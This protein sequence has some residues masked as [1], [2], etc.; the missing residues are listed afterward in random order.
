MPSLGRKLLMAGLSGLNLTHAEPYERLVAR[1]GDAAP[2]LRAALDAFPPEALRG[3]AEGLGQATFV[4]SSGRVFPR[5]WKASPLLRAWLARLDGLGVQVRLRHRWVGIEPD[6]AL[7]F[8][9]PRGARDV[10]RGRD[11][12]GAGRGEL[13]A[14]RLGRRVAGGGG[15]ARY[16]FRAVPPRELRSARRLVG[17]HGALRRRAA[18]AHCALVRGTQPTRR[19]GDDRRRS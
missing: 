6:G 19:D 3:W 16:P 5:A 13:A 11:R 2:R 14:A 10:R 4:G 17:A 7:A 18:E 8:D 1:Y 9:T 15:R 12:P